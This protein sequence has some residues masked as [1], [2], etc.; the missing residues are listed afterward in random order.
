MSKGHFALLA[1]LHSDLYRTRAFER[2]LRYYSLSIS[3][4][5]SCDPTEQAEIALRP[6]VQSCHDF[7]ISS[8]PTTIK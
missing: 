6:P 1:K 3:S 8:N 5:N 2:R 7:A 4:G